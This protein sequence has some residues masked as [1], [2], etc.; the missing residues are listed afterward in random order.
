MALIKRLIAFHKLLNLQSY[1]PDIRL[2]GL[3]F[4]RADERSC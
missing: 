3:R 4:R 1:N 2:V